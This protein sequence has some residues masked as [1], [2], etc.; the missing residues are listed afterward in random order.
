MPLN[1]ALEGKLYPAAEYKVTAEA[2]HKYAAATNETDARFTGRDPVAP[3]AFPIAVAGE[4]IRAVMTDPQLGVNLPRLVH[5]HE[6]HNFNRVI[7][8]GDVLTVES[9]L[10]NVRASEQGA[11]TF[12]IVT[13]LKAPGGEVAVFMV[14]TMLIR[15][16]GGGRAKAAGDAEDEEVGEYLFETTETIDEH[17]TFRYAEASGDHNKIHTDREFARNSGFP[18]IIVHGMCTMAFA[19]RAVLAS[20]AGGDPERLLNISVGFSRPVFP[21]QELTTR[22]WLQ[23]WLK[24]NGEGLKAISFETLNPRGQAVLSEGVAE[25][26]G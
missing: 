7:R 8:A 21:G 10:D 26:A 16:R 13:D 25:I 11:E 20:A 5:S 18:G 15:G 9:R 19:C 6:S 2:I 14:T 4:N 24:S 3:P 23:Y 12:D 1:P 22:G 17:Q